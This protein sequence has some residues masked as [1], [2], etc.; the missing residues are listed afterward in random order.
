L[1]DKQVIL[2]ML[3]DILERMEK[4]AIKIEILKEKLKNE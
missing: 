3:D 2:A 4:S 1:I